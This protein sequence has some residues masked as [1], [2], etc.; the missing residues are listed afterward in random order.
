M[1]GLEPT[2]APLWDSATGRDPYWSGLRGQ[3]VSP[4]I[5]TP[6]PFLAGGPG[7][8]ML[9]AGAAPSP[10]GPGRTHLGPATAAAERAPR[11]TLP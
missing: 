7:P 4:S 3:T 5:E 10:H 6:F 8:P 2:P 11:G 9:Q 1:E